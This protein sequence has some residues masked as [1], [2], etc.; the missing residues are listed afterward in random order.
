LLVSWVADVV[1]AWAIFVL[2]VMVVAFC[3]G[4]LGWGREE[5]SPK[6]KFINGVNKLNQEWMAKHPWLAKRLREEGVRK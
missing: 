2:I 4:W 5:L 1:V 6:I 3:T